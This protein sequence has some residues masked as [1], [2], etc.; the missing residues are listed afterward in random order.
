MKRFLIT[1]LV[2]L[3][4]STAQAGFF[5]G[6]GSSSVDAASTSAAGKVELATDAETVTGSATDRVTTPANIT[7]RL[8][9]PGAIG[10]TTPGAGSFSS[11]TVTGLTASK[12][13]FTDGSKGL[14]SSGTMPVA[15]GGT[16]LTALGTAGQ[17]LRVNSGASA[18]EYGTVSSTVPIGHLSGLI[19]SRKDNDEIYISGGSIEMGGVLY[20]SDEQLAVAPGGEPTGYGSDQCTGGTPSASSDPTSQVAYAFDDNIGTYSGWLSDPDPNSWI[21]YQ[22]AAPKRIQKLTMTQGGQYS[23]TSAPPGAFSLKASY[24]GAFAGEEVTLYS[25]SG[26]TYGDTETKEFTFEN[27]NSYTYYRVVMTAFASGKSYYW[28]LEMEMIEASYA[29]VASTPYYVYADPPGSG[30]ELAVGNFILSATA[31]SFDSAKGGYYHP[32]STDQ[33]AIATFTTDGDGYVPTTGF[34]MYDPVPRPS[35]SDT[36]A[37]IMELATN[38]ETAAGTATD[39]VLTPSNLAAVYQYQTLY[40][41]ASAMT[42]ATT[43]GAAAG[44]AETSSNKLN[45]NYLAFD[46]T[47]EEM[48]HFQLAMPEGWDRSTIKAKFFWSSATSSTAGDTVEWE[49]ACV[50]ISDNDAL[51]AAVGTSQVISDTLLADNGGDLQVSGATP[52]L[53]VGGTPALADMVHCRVSRNVGGTDDMTEDAW[54]F[55][56]WIQYK[57]TN[58]VAA[59]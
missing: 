42:P 56:A 9:A 36:Y 43:N 15:Q 12:P 26:L 10:G 25:T 27:E 2:L 24:T 49:L 40:I 14:S 41:P 21:Q 29:L 59:W 37:G 6:G 38:A 47:T 3:F 32:T 5:S 39:K 35:A 28:I 31:P 7:A 46:T 54:L 51:D 23:A 50:A 30:V 16:G 8:A 1:L 11:V 4:A 45:M 20:N 17:V 19:V 13:V 57:V 52:A 18:L 58:T 48:A 53:T 55:G 34:I 33:R 44:K 22:F